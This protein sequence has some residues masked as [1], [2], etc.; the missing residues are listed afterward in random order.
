VQTAE[1][2]DSSSALNNTGADTNST[3]TSGDSKDDKTDT[4]ATTEAVVKSDDNQTNVEAIDA[5]EPS[6]SVTSDTTTPETTGPSVGDSGIESGT[7]AAA[8]VAEL[9]AS[10]GHPESEL[11]APIGDQ[12]EVSDSAPVDKV[13]SNKAQVAV[14]GDQPLSA[15]IASD[16][17]KNGIDA[18]LTSDA[19]DDQTTAPVAVVEPPLQSTKDSSNTTTTTPTEPP[20][21]TETIASNAT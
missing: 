17:T 11:T 3:D 20:I 19:I 12:R 13:D 5:K 7:T 21:P 8:P 14:S 1:L 16:D 6:L 4:I 15:G 2:T 18:S 10:N 9:P